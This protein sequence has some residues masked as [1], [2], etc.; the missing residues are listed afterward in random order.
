MKI[1]EL[2]PSGNGYWFDTTGEHLS[3]TDNFG[4][5]FFRG[6]WPTIKLRRL[7]EKGRL[8]EYSDATYITMNIIMFKKIVVDTLSEFFTD[9]CEAVPYQYKG[10]AFYL[11]NAPSIDGCILSKKSYSCQIYDLSA[12]KPIGCMA[13][14]TT[15]FDDRMISG[16]DLFQDITKWSCI[17]ASDSFKKAYEH[18]GFHDLSFIECYDSEEKDKL[19]LKRI[20]GNNFIVRNASMAKRLLSI[21]K[22]EDSNYQYRIN[23]TDGSTPE[24]A[25]HCELTALTEEQIRS[26][27]HEELLSTMLQLLASAE[28]PQKV[29][30]LYYFDGEMFQLQ[31]IVTNDIQ[32]EYRWEYESNC[33]AVQC[34]ESIIKRFLKKSSIIDDFERCDAC[35]CEIERITNN[36]LQ[37]IKKTDTVISLK[38]DVCDM[39]QFD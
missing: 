9:D 35:C 37:A 7:Q 36:I 16:Y 39:K 17:Y 29:E 22:A 13:F 24:N 30:T 4:K 5:V 34:Y 38:V 14:G 26:L 31:Q 11:L 25:D 18:A 28:R 3:F 20:A 27:L 23:I 33:L 10:E 8:K 1:W 2:R 6:N 15:I 12:D 21:D 32:E 19:D